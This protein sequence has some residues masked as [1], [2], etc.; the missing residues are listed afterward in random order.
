[1]KAGWTE[2]ELGEVSTSR[3]GKML[4]PLAKTGTAELPYLGNAEV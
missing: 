3:L 4:S 1:V 2:V